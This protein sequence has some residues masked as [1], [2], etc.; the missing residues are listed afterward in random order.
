MNSA[1]NESINRKNLMKKTDE[2]IAILKILKL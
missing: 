1:S 2:E